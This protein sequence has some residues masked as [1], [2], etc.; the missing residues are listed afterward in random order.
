LISVLSFKGLLPPPRGTMEGVTV[1][2]L[3]YKL[4]VHLLGFYGV[5][6]LASRLSQGVSQLEL[7]L[8][9]Q[10]GRLEELQLRHRDIVQSIPS[11]LLTTNLRGTITSLNRAGEE[12]LGITAESIVGAPIWEHRI[13]TPEQWERFNLEPELGTR[14]R[15]EI[16]WQ[17]SDGM[18][19]IGFSLTAL[20]SLGDKPAGWVLVFQ[21]LTRWR[22]L[23]DDMRLKDR[24]AAVGEMA[25]GIAH[26]VGNPLAA[27]SGSVQMLS[28]AASEDSPQRRLLDIVFKESQRLNRTIKGFL[29]FARPAERSIVEF[30]VCR[31]LSENV[32]LLRNS[33]EV[34]PDH[35]IELQLE[36]SKVLITADPDQ[37]SQLFWNLARNA[38]RSMKAGGTLT[39]EGR[40]S[41][42][43]YGLIFRD[44][45]CGMTETERRKMF[46]PFQSGFGEGTGVGMSIVYRI[47]QEHGGHLEVKSE[48]DRGTEVSVLLPAR[49]DSHRT[50]TGRA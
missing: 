1:W 26:E 8:E 36:P 41:A 11:G 38:L 13:L 40:L 33:K 37:I 5:A 30:D 9:E 20:A 43:N 21:D 42:G 35:A 22:R 6:Q 24:M 18:R 31:M 14:Q 49:L 50:A 45:G 48:V 39:I 4:G 2:V 17:R 23:E 27:I 15:N 25:A 19:H 34:S 28:N 44:T 12:I 29:Q 32:D 10:T 3:V 7:E 16:D 47:V 46:H